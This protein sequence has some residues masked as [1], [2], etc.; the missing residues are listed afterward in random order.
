MK[1]GNL[2]QFFT[3]AEKNIK[4]LWNDRIIRI[5]LIKI[6]VLV[7]FG[8]I[9]WL[10]RMN[11]IEPFYNY[12]NSSKFLEYFK[13]TL[14]FFTYLLLKLL[15]ENAIVNYQDSVVGIISGRS[16]FLG[17][18]CYGLKLMGIFAVFIIAYPGKNF[19]RLLFI[20]GG[21]IFIQMLNVIRL[22]G[23]VIIYTYYPQYFNINHHV[24][25]TTAVYIFVFIMWV[26]WTKM[27]QRQIKIPGKD[28]K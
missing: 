12:A 3:I 15:G 16:V 6:S 24:I 19:Y 7:S 21:C 26:I 22:A 25:F 13:N 11:H 2:P 5:F 27:Y 4:D 14:V 8:F 18:P 28:I 1:P 17:I 23:L 10:I 20:L 9:I